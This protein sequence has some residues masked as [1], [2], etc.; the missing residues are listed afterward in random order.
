MEAEE[1]KEE[2]EPS[3]PKIWIFLIFPLSTYFFPVGE[4]NTLFYKIFNIIISVHV[5]DMRYRPFRNHLGPQNTQKHTKPIFVLSLEL[6]LTC[7]YTFLNQ[8]WL[9]WMT[10][11]F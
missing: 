8:F 4:V 6:L 10:I 5:L 11:Y 2:E 3:I 9:I 1:E 7:I